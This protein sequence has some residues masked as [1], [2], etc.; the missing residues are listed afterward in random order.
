MATILYS[1]LLN[2][3]VNILV[4]TP[5]TIFETILETILVNIPV[6][7]LH[8]LRVS[9]DIITPRVCPDRRLRMLTLFTTQPPVS[10]L[11]LIPSPAT[12]GAGT[13]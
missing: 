6:S 7:F 8:L 5:E 2:I 3:L 12:T 13:W 9:Q 11:S 10:I 1:S 4:N